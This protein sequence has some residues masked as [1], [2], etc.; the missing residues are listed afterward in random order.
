MPRLDGYGLLRRMRGSKAQRLRD[1][2]VV[3]VSG[4]DE[5]EERRLAREAG[6]PFEERPFSLEE[7]YRAREAFVSSASTFVNMPRPA[8][9]EQ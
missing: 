3:V 6:I 9:A 5:L 2:P 7:A 4:A 8:F 1:M